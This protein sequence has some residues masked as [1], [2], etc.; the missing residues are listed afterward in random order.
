MNYHLA[1]AREVNRLWLEGWGC[2]VREP[3]FCVLVSHAEFEEF[4]AIYDLRGPD[5]LDRALELAGSA[6]PYAPSAVTI[7][8]P[9]EGRF[10][11]ARSRM[12]GIGYRPAFRTAT[13]AAQIPA[14]HP[15]RESSIS[16]T[17]VV[18]DTI[19]QWIELY[20]QNYR[21][22]PTQAAREHERWRD[23]FFRAGQIRFFLIQMDATDV[24]TV[25]LVTSQ[26]GWCGVYALSMP[27]AARGVRMLE[28][29]YTRLG[30]E[31]GDLGCQWVFFDR[32]RP[33]KHHPVETRS[34]AARRRYGL[35]W[36]LLSAE[37]GF[38]K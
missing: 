5:D 34:V 18:P 2:T 7:Y 16:L 27:P 24:G 35:D 22:A 26:S 6:F 21:V 4:N 38:Q 9:C 37:L 32:L 36:M 31:I 25:Q 17:P 28:Q 15:S 10:E 30:R 8:L 11:R 14:L 29:L 19:G 20:Q 12:I 1:R 23:M 3:G 13:W 33:A